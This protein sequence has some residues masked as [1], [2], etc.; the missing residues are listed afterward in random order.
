MKTVA[1]MNEALS[2]LEALGAELVDR[3]PEPGCEACSPA[4]DIAA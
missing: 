3:C 4:L 2:A 1:V